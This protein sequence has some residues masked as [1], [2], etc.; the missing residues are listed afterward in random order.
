MTRAELVDLVSRIMSAD[1]SEQELDELLRL[2]KR[3]VPHPEVTDL[4]FHPLREMTPE[5]VVE[6][7][8]SYRPI[9]LGP[10]E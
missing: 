8:L 7:A 3:N 5:E 10:K 4:I 6:T 2:L 1:G 9:E